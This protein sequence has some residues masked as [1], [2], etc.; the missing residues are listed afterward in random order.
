MLS[1]SGT[2]SKQ[3]KARKV[4]TLWAG[5]VVQSES[6]A[7]QF[8]R[9]QRRLLPLAADAYIEFTSRRGQLP[10]ELQR[11]QPLCRHS[12]N[13]FGDRV[14]S[15]TTWLASIVA[16]GARTSGGCVSQ[17]TGVMGTVKGG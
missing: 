17:S 1:E 2:G 8:L 10:A 7:V 3:Q 15:R 13:P 12:A 6:R 9:T 14:D 11:Q 16:T 4:C 5:L